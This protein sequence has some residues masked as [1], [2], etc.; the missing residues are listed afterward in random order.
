[1]VSVHSFSSLMAYAVTFV[2][3]QRC[4]IH[5]LKISAESSQFGIQFLNMIVISKS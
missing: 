1:M 5:L 4:K 3:K 2:Y